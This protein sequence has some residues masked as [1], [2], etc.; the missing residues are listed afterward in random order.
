MKFWPRHTASCKISL[1]RSYVELT[2]REASVVHL[3]SALLTFHLRNVEA[4]FGGA[5]S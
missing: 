1:A 3:I 4:G 5:M 2:S